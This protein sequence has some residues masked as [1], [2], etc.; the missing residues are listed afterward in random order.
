M[1]R[2]QPVKFTGEYD[3]ADSAKGSVGALRLIAGRSI[4]IA[5]GPCHGPKGLRTVSWA[6]SGPTS[7]PTFTGPLSLR[8]PLA[9]A[10][11]ANA[12]I[13]GKLDGDQMKVQARS[14]RKQLCLGSCGR[15]N[16][17]RASPESARL[18]T[19]DNIQVRSRGGWLGTAFREIPPSGIDAPALRL[20]P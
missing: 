7:P 1:I 19:R 14:Y 11:D 18:L 13:L 5:H 10:L 9:K 12:L 2:P 8:R 15:R 17:I 4:G 16:A 3:V 6:L 20:T